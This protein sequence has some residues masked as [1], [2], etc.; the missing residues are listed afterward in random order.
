[1][2]LNKLCLFMLL[3]VCIGCTLVNMSFRMVVLCLCRYFNCTVCVCIFF[4]F[5][6]CQSVLL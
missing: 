3:T 6:Y 2:I 4:F 5:P 1:L